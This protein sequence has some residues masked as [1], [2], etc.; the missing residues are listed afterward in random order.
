MTRSQCGANGAT[1]S[2]TRT[3]V[4][5]LDDGRI[6]LRHLRYGRGLG[7][8][9]AQRTVLA[10]E[11]AAELSDMLRATLSSAPLTSATRPS[12]AESSRNGSSATGSSADPAARATKGS[13]DLGKVVYLADRR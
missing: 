5:R 10:P 9:A 3:D 11:A 7:W 8:Y 1:K 13:A 12:V 6:E 4:R 2:E